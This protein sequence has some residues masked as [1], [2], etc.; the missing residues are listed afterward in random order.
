MANGVGVTVKTQ[1]FASKEQKGNTGH[2]SV[3]HTHSTSGKPVMK[4][5]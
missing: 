2:S 4:P 1:V 3:V 5:P